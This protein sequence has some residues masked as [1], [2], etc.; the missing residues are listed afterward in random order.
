[1]S[2]IAEGGTVSITGGY[3]T[4]VWARTL[5]KYISGG[6]FYA[7][8]TATYIADGLMAIPGTYSN[9]VEP[10]DTRTYNFEIAEGVI[11]EA[12]SR[13]KLGSLPT[14]SI[15]GAGPVKKNASYTLTAP[16]VEGYSFLGWYEGTTELGTDATYTATATAAKTIEAVYEY[17]AADGFSVTVNGTT[18]YTIKG[19]MVGT[20]YVA[21]S[22]ITVVYNGTDEFQCWTNESGKLVSRD[23]SYSFD[24]AADTTL[25]AN[26]ITSEGQLVIFY[27]ANNQVI[28]TRVNANGVTNALTDADFASVPTVAG[29]KNGRWTVDGQTVTSVEE[30]NTIAGRTTSVNVIAAYDNDDA[31][32]YN[33][34][35]LGVE[36]GTT[37]TPDTWTAYATG[38]QSFSNVNITATVKLNAP[39]G[40]KTFLYYAD[41]AGNLLS[42][43]AETYVRYQAD[44]T[45]YAVYGTTAP[46][47]KPTITMITAKRENGAVYFE[48]LRDIP[49]GYTLKEQG[50]LFS[51]SADIVY[52]KTGVYKYVS[53][54][55]SFNDVTGLTI[56]NAPTPMYGRGYMILSD[57]TNEGILYTDEVQVP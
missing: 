8:P 18:D 1:A 33:L 4:R 48:A 15:E 39:A 41:A 54:G 56:K 37:G 3:V 6:F 40:D 46:A 27:T 45:I 22:T 21:G 51:L 7:K 36:E 42:T 38:N 44:T 17:G 2:W 12:T 55:L 32:V 50:I 19:E 29:K 57:G 24:L 30:M 16:A 43:N 28:K 31:A 35:V 49:A 5:T 11:I 34:T 10:S 53:S 52:G 14:T 47:A 13:A 25:T 20:K 9:A 23:E 26:V